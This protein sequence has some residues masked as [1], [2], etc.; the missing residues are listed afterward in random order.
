MGEL[1]FASAVGE[2]E[3]QS[4]MV[5]R[6][7]MRSGAAGRGAPCGMWVDGWVECVR[8]RVWMCWRVGRRGGG[9]K[10]GKLQAD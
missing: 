3:G 8:A 4:E 6:Q 9:G 10:E 7:R 1:H 2:R 5:R